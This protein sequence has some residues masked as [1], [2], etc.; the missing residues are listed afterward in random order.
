MKERVS[1]IMMNITIDGYGR[2]EVTF[3]YDNATSF[4]YQLGVGVL[5]DKVSIGLHWYNL[6][7]VKVKGEMISSTSVTDYYYDS[8]S[9][10]Y[11]SDSESFT[12]KRLSTSMLTLKIGFHF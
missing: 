9:E 1:S 8:D 6:G 12:W 3:R 2:S 5:F 4:A 11:D 10:Y 7:S